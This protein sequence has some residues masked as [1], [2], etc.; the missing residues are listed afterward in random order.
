VILVVGATGNLGGHVVQM[1]R[2]GGEPVR[3]LVRSSSDTTRL[4]AS[5]AEIVHGDLTQPWSLDAAC[6]GVHTVVLTA[7]AITAL[8]A[9]ARR[10]SIREVDHLG[11]AALIEAAEDGGVSRF[12][13]LSYAGVDAGLGHPIERAKLA[14]EARL[15]DS[16]MRATIV[17]P[18][19][20]QEIH[21][22][23]VGRFDLQRGR[24]A[25][26]GG[27]DAP[28]RWVSTSDVAAL[29]SAVATEADPPDLV[30]FGGPEQLSRNQ[31]IALAENL[32][33]RPLRR[34]Q[35]PHAVARFVIR[36][37][38]RP[39]PVIASVLGLGLLQDMPSSG[40]DDEPLRLRGIQPRSASEFL[41]TQVESLRAL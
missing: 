38:S 9:G 21:L 3:C 27:G 11:T 23:A 7:S 2:H 40:W 10:P 1:L 25:V 17:R 15:Q 35:V 6:A 29:V 33:G 41:R 8:L 14:I 28:R 31:A 26:F 5:G 39:R 36:A 30:Q 32:T 20:F 34:R 37:L 4:E 13:Y 22:T 12:V 18:D 16:P 19:V 24:V